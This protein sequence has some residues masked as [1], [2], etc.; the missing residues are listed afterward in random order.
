MITVDNVKQQA[1]DITFGQW[2]ALQVAWNYRNET[3]GT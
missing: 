3:V 1:L 2:E